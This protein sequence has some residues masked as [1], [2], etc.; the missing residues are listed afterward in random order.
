MTRRAPLSPPTPK[1]IQVRNYNRMRRPEYTLEEY[2]AWR[3]QVRRY[4]EFKTHLRQ[5]IPL[6]RAFL[7][8]DGVED[9]IATNRYL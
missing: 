3:Q 1:H 4:H 2:L 8:W 9:L 6:E 7:E 5:D